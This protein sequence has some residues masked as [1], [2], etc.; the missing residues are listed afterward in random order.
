MRA[1]YLG[2][3]FSRRALWQLRRPDRAAPG[4]KALPRSTPRATQ[5][6]VP[7]PACRLHHPFSGPARAKMCG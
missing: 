5:R 4:L 2:R 6:R 1:G 3:G 7:Q